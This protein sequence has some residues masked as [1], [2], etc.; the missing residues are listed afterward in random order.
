MKPVDG[1]GPAK[2]ASDPVALRLPRL[3]P[4]WLVI[5]LLAVLAALVL[6][7]STGPVALPLPGVAKEL[8]ALLPGVDLDSGLSERERA[9]LVEL[10][11][12]RVV[13][14]LLVGG[15]LALA[16]ACYQG[17]FRN[18][19]ADPH[20]L[21]VAAGAGLGVTAVITLR[22]GAGGS[23]T[24]ALPLATP[25]AAFV[26][27]VAAVALTYALAT[28]GGD[29]SPATLILAGVAVS[30]FLSAGQTFLMQR[31]ADAIR[32]IYSWLLGRLG[33]AG[34]RDVLLVLPYAVV[35]AVV[36]LAHRRD[37][38]VLAVGDAEAAGLGLDPQRTRYVLTAAAS[39]GTAAAVSVSG[40]IGFVGIIV[41]HTVRLLAGASHRT[42]LPV[43]MLVGGAFL[44]LADLVA[45][46]AAAPAEIPIGVVTAFL[47]APFFVLVLRTGARTRL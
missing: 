10:R 44:V 16:G 35:T 12:P 40:L 45:R 20:L 6:G 1:G 39:L 7:V 25:L 41:P 5:G 14:G 21:G 15:L 24:A 3:R 29:R 43:S 27:A 31:D 32:E 17:V 47:G 38:D 46:T 30:A 9:L 11:L 8:L 36:V 34:W 22:R 37:L 33:T 4:V 28:G 13:L 19:L 18:P 2:Q 26:G 42:I 23:A